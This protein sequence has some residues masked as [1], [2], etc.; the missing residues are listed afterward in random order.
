M[1]KLKELTFRELVEA[2]VTAS[3][4]KELDEVYKELNTRE[5]WMKGSVR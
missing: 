2:S 1:K 3:T 5:F 4:Q